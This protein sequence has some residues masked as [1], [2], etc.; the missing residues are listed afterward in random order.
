MKAELYPTF[1]ELQAGLTQMLDQR[2]VVHYLSYTS[3][4][5]VCRV[6]RA[7]VGNQLNDE[8]RRHEP[9]GSREA[10]RGHFCVPASSREWCRIKPKG[11]QA[12]QA[13]TP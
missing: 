5:W 2:Y 6:R 4:G 9:P 8:A 7:F 10:D 3:E 11:V 12:D 1:A 13:G